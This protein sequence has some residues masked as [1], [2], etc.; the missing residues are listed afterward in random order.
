MIG[1]L[2]DKKGIIIKTVALSGNPS[3]YHIPVFRPLTSHF[4]EEIADTN[5]ISEFRHMVF[6]LE[7]HDDTFSVYR[8]DCII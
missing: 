2:I 7:D 8:F 5:S 3:E 1:Y 4:W 6:K